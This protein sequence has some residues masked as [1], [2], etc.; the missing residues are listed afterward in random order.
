MNTNPPLMG[1]VDHCAEQL[2]NAHLFQAPEEY[3]QKGA[4]LLSQM[5]GSKMQVTQYYSDITVMPMKWQKYYIQALSFGI[6][7]T[8]FKITNWQCKLNENLTEVK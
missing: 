3:M 5:K 6:M 2:E 7:R 4:N 1:T 8:R